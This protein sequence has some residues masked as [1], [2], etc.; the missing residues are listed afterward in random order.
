MHV[1]GQMLHNSKSLTELMLIVLPST[2]VLVYG[3]IKVSNTGKRKNWSLSVG[4][5]P[6]VTV[7]DRLGLSQEDRSHIVHIRICFKQLTTQ[8][9]KRE[10]RLVPCFTF[11]LW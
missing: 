11:P 1:I 9:D 8:E 10:R 3:D 2:V 4:K 6:V 7:T 5:N